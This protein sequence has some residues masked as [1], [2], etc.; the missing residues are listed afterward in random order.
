MNRLPDKIIDLG[1]EGGDLD[2]K[3][4][5]DLK[6]VDYDALIVEQHELLA[7]LLRN[8]EL[9]EADSLLRPLAAN[10]KKR[11][12]KQVFGIDVLMAEVGPGDPPVMRK[13]VIVED[14]LVANPEAK[15]R[16]IGQILGYAEKLH[17]AG[18]DELLENLRAEDRAWL[19]SGEN[20]EQL[21]IC[22]RTRKFLLLVC[23]NRIHERVELLIARLKNRA[24]SAIELTEMA[25]IS[26]NIYENKGG[27]R[28][29]LVPVLVDGLSLSTQ[30]L[31]LRVVVK[32][33]EHPLKITEIAVDLTL[34]GSTR[35][36]KRNKQTEVEFFAA[37]R[38][39]HGDTNFGHCQLVLKAVDEAGIPNLSRTNT[40][41]GAPQYVFA[42][43]MLG[44]QH[45]FR[46]RTSQAGLMD[47]LYTQ[48]DAWKKHPRAQKA[49]DE[50]RSKLERMGRTK[51]EKKGNLTIP[52]SVV[53][54]H[55]A[56]F[57]ACLQSLGQ[58]LGG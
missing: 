46:V 4:P 30:D 56:E 45:V 57:V 53:A 15:T 19:E 42:N 32:A 2:L 48:E 5:K 55:V 7:S 13:L 11:G 10:Y 23:G 51:R 47:A 6:E 12:L 28:R 21:D 31:T 43:S 36:Q 26:L 49:R 58:G 39:R 22:F 44:D 14:K 18:L 34:A 33:S 38:K 54:E 40:D 29:V 16:V 25:A 27:T 41:T 52:V 37:W 35:E 8:A 3:E 1:P 17:Q 24:T 20:R 50:F 9:L